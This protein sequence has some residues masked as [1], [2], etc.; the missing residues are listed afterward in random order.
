VHGFFYAKAG[1]SG[2]GEREPLDARTFDRDDPQHYMWY[3][4]TIQ[5]GR[6]SWVG[7]Y[8][9]TLLDEMQICSYLV[10][11]Y[12]AGTFVGVLGMDVPVSTLIEQVSSISV[13]E[14]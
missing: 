12:K 9:T 8:A 3:Y 5:R 11:I 13:Y 6:P 2:F 1:K 10:P 7:P 4:V 14:T